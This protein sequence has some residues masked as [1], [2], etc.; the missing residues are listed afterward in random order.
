[1]DF[2][3]MNK[4]LRSC[5]SRVAC[6]ASRLISPWSARISSPTWGVLL[7]GAIEPIRDRRNEASI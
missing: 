3:V 5:R 4:D 7:I 2:A 1:M 6:R